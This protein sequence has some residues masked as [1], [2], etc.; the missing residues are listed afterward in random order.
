VNNGNPETFSG[1]GPPTETPAA[2]TAVYVDKSTGI[3]YYYANGAW[4]T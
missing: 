3:I 1:Y 2:D 4:S